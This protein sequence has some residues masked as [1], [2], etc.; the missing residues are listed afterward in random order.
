MDAMRVVALAVI[1]MVG[2][3]AVAPGYYRNHS[4]MEICT[5]LM[6]IP[7]YNFNHGERMRELERRGAN[8]SQYGSVPA[9]Q[10]EADRHMQLLP[11]LPDS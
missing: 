3:C 11:Q 7:S 4:T 2:G 6:T 1:L 5:G 9:A 8:C 10:A